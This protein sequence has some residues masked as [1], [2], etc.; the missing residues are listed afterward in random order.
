MQKP[1]F[2]SQQKTLS[3]CCVSQV[4]CNTDLAVLHLPQLAKPFP[5]CSFSGRFR[6]WRK[7][8]KT[9]FLDRVLFEWACTQQ[10]RRGFLAKH[11]FSQLQLFL[12]T[13]RA[14]KQHHWGR[15]AFSL[16]T[17]SLAKKHKCTRPSRDTLGTLFRNSAGRG[18]PPPPPL[19]EVKHSQRHFWA[20][21]AALLPEPRLPS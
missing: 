9:P 21:F 4:F 17:I 12:G 13:E 3:K 20:C 10:Q 7:Q 11:T 19:E 6:R 8:R 5:K 1:E 14:L 2:L 16:S 18:L 15:A